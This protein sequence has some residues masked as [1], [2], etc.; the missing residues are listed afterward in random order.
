[1]ALASSRAC[2][3]SRARWIPAIGPKISSRASSMSGVTSGEDPRAEHLSV[4]AA[5]Q[6][7]GRAFAA[8][9]ADLLFQALELL[10][11]DDRADHG[12]RIGRVADL[13][14]RTRAVKRSTN[15]SWTRVV[16]DDAVD[17]HADLALVQE[18]A[19]DRRVDGEVEVGVV[20]DDE[21]AVPAQLECH[22]LEHLAAGGELADVR[23]TAVEPVNEITRGTG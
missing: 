10:G 1:M 19:E 2:S 17:R 23:P 3:A 4:G 15:S 20:E 21:R 8:G 14:G 18:L 22:L 11:V 5:F 6:D 16:D 9:G 12:L 7:G 13:Q